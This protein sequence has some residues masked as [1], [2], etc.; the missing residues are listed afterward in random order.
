MKHLEL[1]DSLAEVLSVED[2]DQALGSVV[3]ANGL[4]DENLEGTILDPLLHVLLVLLGVDITQALVTDNEA[5]HG[6]TLDKDVV[7]VLDG[8]GSG[9]VL[10]DETADDDTAEV[11]H[12]LKGSL[13]V[14]ATDV[15]V[16]D[17]DTLGGKT[18]KSISGLLG[19]VVE[20]LEAES[21]GDVL[22]LLV[23]TDGADD[24]QALVLG[25]LANELADGTAGSGDEDGLAL[26]G[27]ADLVQGGV[28]GQTGHAE[29][30]EE[31]AEV[32]EAERVL[33]LADADELLLADGDELL[34]GN[35]TDDQVAF[36]VVGVVGADDLADGG[37]LNG[38]VKVEGGS[39]GL[40]ASIAHAATHVRVEAG[41]EGL[42]DDTVV[43]GSNV[44]VI[45]GGLN[46]K[47][48]PGLG[49]SLGDL[50][51]DESLVGHGE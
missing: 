19:L 42:E 3:N 25:E 36:L 47:I 5:A 2:T 26:L 7:D 27:L 48:L 12:G 31:D 21:L 35:V 24:A 13:E 33:E 37:T 16:V 50:L 49:V 41:V 4:V 20:A 8:V 34:D 39:V 1:Q 18:G 32:L 40:G 38:L 30:T 45:G 46:G 44:G 17:V 29:G 23:G 28:C 9:V 14:L 51:E 15:L 22:E 43:G 11:V 10:G 6:N